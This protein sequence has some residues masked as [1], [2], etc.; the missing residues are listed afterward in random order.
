[1]MHYDIIGSIEAHWHRH[2]SCQFLRGQ[3]IYTHT[4]YIK[5]NIYIT[6]KHSY[7]IYRV[8]LVVSTFSSIFCLSPLQKALSV[9]ACHLCIAACNFTRPRQPY[10]FSAIERRTHND[11]GDLDTL[12][13]SI[14]I[15]QVCIKQQ[16]TFDLC[17][18]LSDNGFDAATEQ[19]STGAVVAELLRTH[20]NL[21][22]LDVLV[23][24]RWAAKV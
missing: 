7:S 2:I 23:E 10:S 11:Y 21:D 12:Y 3:I 18:H 8:T 24:P 17:T 14:Y 20:I 13:Y 1:M 15:P 4:T 6:Y 22:E 16:Y 9:G 5:C 19:Y